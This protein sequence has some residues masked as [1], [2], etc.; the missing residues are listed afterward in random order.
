MNFVIWGLIH[1]TFSV[2]EEKGNW[3]KKIKDSPIGWLYTM[4]VV[5]VAF[6]FFRCETLSQSAA[7]IRA[8]FTF[9][10]GS[11]GAATFIE[12]MDPFTIAM[13][14]MGLILMFNWKRKMPEEGIPVK[15]SYIASLLLFML[16]VMGL[17]SGSY[18]PFI[19]FRF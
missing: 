4:L 9:S 15:L 3:I 19:Y 16:S 10:A 8:M 5:V 6:V 7:V 17:I 13:A 12:Y 2:L 1:G 18:N 14:V 11:E